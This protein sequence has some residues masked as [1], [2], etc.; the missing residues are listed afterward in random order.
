MAN[1][2]PAYGFVVSTHVYPQQG[3]V[4]QNRTQT[5]SAPAVTSRLGMFFQR[6]PSALGTV[7]IMIGIVIFLVGIVKVIYPEEIMTFSGITFWGAIIF[8]TAGSLTVKANE[9]LDLCLVKASLGMN[10][11]STIAA[12]AAITLN[13]IEM[14]LVT[15][16]GY[17]YDYPC[18]MIDSSYCDT[19]P[20]IDR[21]DKLLSMLYGIDGVMMVLLLLEVIVSI[22]VS[23][24]ACQTTCCNT[25]TESPAA[26]VANSID[27]NSNRGQLMANSIPA[28]GFVVSTHVYPQ[29][30]QVQQNGTQTGSAPAN[31]VTSR[32]GMF[33]QRNPS[34]LGT[35]EIMIGI[36]IFLFGI[37][38]VIYPGGIVT[39]S[40][41]TFWGAIIYI[42]AGS[43]TVKANED[44]NL[45]LVKASL[46][47]NIISTIAAGAAIILH[48]LSI[49]DDYDIYDYN[50]D[51]DS[52]CQ[53]NNA[54]SGHPFIQRYNKLLSMLYGIDGVMMVLLLLEFIVSICVSAFACQTTCCDTATEVAYVNNAVPLTILNPHLPTAPL[55]NSEVTAGKSSVYYSQPE[56]LSP[57]Y[58]ELGEQV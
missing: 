36:V 41:I 12:G 10:I 58:V 9:D 13:S 56:D 21:F 45:C 23:A 42:T 15:P 14:I 48:S 8:I 34:A 22:C 26:T 11:I 32:L 20:F 6:N 52:W 44:L 38:N 27:L 54:C 37:V 24:F 49:T 28:Y 47:M 30:G 1:S 19:Y 51:Y 33:F 29:Q 53:E 7:E 55:N 4:Q 40:G 16:P 18:P 43:L 3:Q 39:F 50:D 35:V 2:I 57:T 17:I 31:S 5:G 46:G 25:T